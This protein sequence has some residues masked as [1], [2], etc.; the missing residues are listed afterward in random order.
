MTVKACHV[1]SRQSSA[2]SH[3]G[4]Q[5]STPG[6]SISKRKP[7]QM[8]RSSKDE[9]ELKVPSV[10]R[11]PCECGKVYVGQ[12]GR[13]VETRCKEHQRHTPAATR[14]VGSGRT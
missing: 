12:S 7:A 9:L 13:T 4:G 14:E 8:L 1:S 2:A 5:G 10:Y 3:H 6:Y 11:M